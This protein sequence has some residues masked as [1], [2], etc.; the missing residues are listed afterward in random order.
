MYYSNHPIEFLI[1]YFYWRFGSI[2]YYSIHA[3]KN[4]GPDEYSAIVYENKHSTESLRPK[5]E[6]P[7]IPENFNINDAI[8]NGV[9]FIDGKEKFDKLK[10]DL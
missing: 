9:H 4:I 10:K 3:L 7:P 5:D 6:G 8:K 1:W 2:L